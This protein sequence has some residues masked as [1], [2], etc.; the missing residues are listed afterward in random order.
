MISDIIKKN[1]YIIIGIGIA[2]I[3]ISSSIG[4]IFLNFNRS[5][6]QAPIIIESDSD[7]LN[8]D[9]TGNGTQ[10]SPYIIEDFRI[11]A[12]GT[13]SFGISISNTYSYVI[14]R[15]CI[16]YSDFVGIRLM[17]VASGR[18]WIIN[19]TCISTSGDGGGIGLHNAN[20]CSIV[21]NT[22][23]NFMQGI[24]LNLA[25]YCVIKSN[26]IKDNNYQGINIRYS[27]FNKITNNTVGMNPQHG[28]ALVGDA[29]S[30]KIYYNKLIENGFSETYNVDGRLTGTIN[31]QGFDEGSN[32]FWYDNLNNQG[33]WW[34]DYQGIGNYSIDGPAGTEDKYPLGIS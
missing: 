28:I 11:G 23:T 19:N 4:I 34:S 13:N 1:K 31:S 5:N 20:N 24:H 26:R 8:Y 7:F 6:L 9:F 33:N 21:N 17:D 18:V 12:S 3:V 10:E 16:V 27:S 30:N 22:C 25:S 2:V 32:N 14:I 15:N 29:N